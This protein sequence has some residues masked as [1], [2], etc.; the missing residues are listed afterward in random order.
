MTFG[1]L[2]GIG[3]PEFMAKL[4]ERRRIEEALAQ[5]MGVTL[6]EA[7]RALYEFEACHCLDGHTLH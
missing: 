7:R 6:G 5:R 1:L 2:S 3:D 4:A